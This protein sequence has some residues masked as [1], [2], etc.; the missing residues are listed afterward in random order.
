[1]ESQIFCIRKLRVLFRKPEGTGDKYPNAMAKTG[2]LQKAKEKTSVD[3]NS[4]QATS[5]LAEAQRT[6]VGLPSCGRNI[7]MGHPQT[8]SHLCPTN[9][10]DISN[11]FN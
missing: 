10:I 4:T 3:S 2:A 5:F 11:T 1:M 6:L 7:H 8:Q 9:L